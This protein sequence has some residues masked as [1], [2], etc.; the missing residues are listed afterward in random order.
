MTPILDI[1]NLKLF[2]EDCVVGLPQLPSESVDMIFA[3]PPFNVGKKYGVNGDKRIDYY[4]W[5]DGWIAECF[6]VLKPSGVFCLMTISKHLGETYPMMHRRGAFINQVMWRNVSASHS[7]RGFWNSY[8][9]VLMYG[10][11]NAYKFNTYAQTRQIEEKNMRWGGYSTEAKGMLLDYWDDI[12]FVYAGS[13]AHKEAILTPKTNKKAHPCQM[14]EMLAGRCIVFFTDPG[15]TV[16]DPF[17][18]SGTTL[19]AARK[20]GRFGIGFEREDEYCTLSM[21]RLERGR[22]VFDVECANA[23]T[24]NCV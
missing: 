5:C 16:L 2:K 1:D 12:P 17:A 7:K 24:A 19:V 10:K 21:K 4:E 3:D 20:L 13:I 18:G 22:T 15:D 9:P 23:M 14:P 11:T 6:R 8:Q